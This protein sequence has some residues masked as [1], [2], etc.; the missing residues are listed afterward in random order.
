MVLCLSWA[1]RGAVL[2]STTCPSSSIASLIAK[3][4]SLED[5]IKVSKDY[6]YNAIKNAPNLGAGNGPINHSLNDL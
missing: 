6:I 1:V 4:Y 5:A 3:N 2:C